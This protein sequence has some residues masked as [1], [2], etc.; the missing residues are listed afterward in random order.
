MHILLRIK[1]QSL[2]IVYIWCLFLVTEHV[3]V[4]D[5][6]ELGDSALRILIECICKYFSQ[7]DIT[8]ICTEVDNRCILLRP[9]QTILYCLI[10]PSLGTSSIYMSNDCQAL[11]LAVITH[12][13]ISCMF[14]CFMHKFCA[15]YK[16]Y[17]HRIQLIFF[18]VIGHSCNGL[19][20]FVGQWCNQ[21]SFSGPRP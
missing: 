21:D 9:V 11:L 3:S 1:N 16:F 19:F 15:P 10:Y 20:Q 18:E 5:V 2:L 7:C 6:Q 8:L 13:I 17:K 14:A 4:S 12:F